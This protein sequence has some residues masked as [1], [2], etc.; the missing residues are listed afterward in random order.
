M[1][2]LALLAIVAIVAACSAP[3]APTEPTAE[4]KPAVVK[5]A[6]FTWS[7]PLGSG[8]VIRTGATAPWEGCEIVGDT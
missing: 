8:A 6:S 4:L 7:C 3:T 2:K 5:P 1:R